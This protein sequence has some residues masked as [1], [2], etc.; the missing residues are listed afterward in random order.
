M[1]LGLMLVIT[2]FKTKWRSTGNISF[3]RLVIAAA[4]LERPE[5]TLS[6]F[7]PVLSD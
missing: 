4:T 3:R 2:T 5:T 6:H 1:H 7:N